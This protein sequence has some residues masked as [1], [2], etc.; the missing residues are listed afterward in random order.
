MSGGLFGVV[1]APISPAPIPPNAA[2]TPAARIFF[3][4][5]SRCGRLLCRPRRGLQRGLG[6]VVVVGPLLGLLRLRDELRPARAEASKSKQRRHRCEARWRAGDEVN[7]AQEKRYIKI[8][9]RD[10][11]YTFVGACDDIWSE[12]VDVRSSSSDSWVYPRVRDACDDEAMDTVR[13]ARRD[14]TTRSTKDTITRA[15]GESGYNV[16]V[17]FGGVDLSARHVSF[18]PPLQNS[19]RTAANVISTTALIL[20]PFGLASS[21]DA[22]IAFASS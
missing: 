17:V 20:L 19:P 10:D 16:V 18:P 6:H 7:A 9:G 22:A 15:P 4:I 21:V 11:E 3:V 14:C 8:G 13:G 1:P 5:H 2:P 12:G